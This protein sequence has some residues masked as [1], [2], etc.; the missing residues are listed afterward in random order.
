MNANKTFILSAVRANERVT[1]LLNDKP[2]TPN[3][4]LKL[5]NHSPDGFNWGYSGSGPS[6]FALAVLLELYGK[7]IALAE[8]Q[9][10]K[11]QVLAGIKADGFRVHVTR[12]S[13]TGVPMYFSKTI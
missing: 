13:I 8:Y 6:Q 11:S 3:E 4:S 12:Q 5:V 10:F 1:V 9:S 7:E 2:L